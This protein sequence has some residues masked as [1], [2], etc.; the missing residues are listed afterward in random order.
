MINKN[1]NKEND[2]LNNILNQNNCEPS[3]DY[4]SGG[5]SL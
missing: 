2:M 5:V 4:I 1:R 3:Y